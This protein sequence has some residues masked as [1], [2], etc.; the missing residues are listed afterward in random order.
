MRGSDGLPLP[1]ARLRVLVDGHADPDGFIDDSAA[2]A[3]MVR[4]TVAGAGQDISELSAI[5]DFGC[6]CGRT[7][8]HW[9]GLEGP[10]IHGCDYN[11]EL[12]AWCEANLPF[13]QVRVNDEEPPAPYPDDSFDLVYA[14]SILTHLTEP[15]A[16]AWI[17][18]MRRILRPGGLL[19]VTTLGQEFGDRLSPR[20]LEQY[21]A[22]VPVVQRAGVEGTNMCAAYHP[23][24]YV[25]DRMLTDFD[26][27]SGPRAEGFPQDVY[28]AR[29]LV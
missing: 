7:A 11:A 8:R 23:E 20:E 3:K 28:L 1:P 16:H 24:A 15:M 26:L 9:A 2:G 6:G 13:M 12:V 14:I 5:L 19:L 4:D 10:E 18:D 22:G 29:S 25:R 21:Q 17:A 27:I